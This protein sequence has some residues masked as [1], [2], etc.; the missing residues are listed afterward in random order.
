MCGAF[1]GQGY[2][3]SERQNFGSTAPGSYNDDRQNTGTG[4]GGSYTG[5]AQGQAQ[6]LGNRA[7]DMGR[8]AYNSAADTVGST[9]GRY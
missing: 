8:Q 1:A 5:Q 9:G 7:A 6:N 4:Q 3:S 2:E